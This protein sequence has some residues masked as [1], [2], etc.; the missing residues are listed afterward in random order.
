MC[1]ENASQL[2]NCTTSA[3][4]PKFDSLPNCH[5]EWAAISHCRSAT[6]GVQLMKEARCILG[7]GAQRFHFP[8][9][10]FYCSALPAHSR[11]LQDK[12]AKTE[13]FIAPRV[14][15]DH[16]TRIPT[17]NIYPRLSIHTPATS[18]T[19]NYSRNVEPDTPF[20]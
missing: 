10:A 4:G 19:K 7:P 11:A 6:A 3:S 16:G 1:S 8:E 17:R 12:G 5:Q 20:Y 9:V 14:L 15:S 2:P 13:Y 18:P